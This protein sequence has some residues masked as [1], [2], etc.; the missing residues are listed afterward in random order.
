MPALTLTPGFPSVNPIGSEGLG[1][2]IDVVTLQTTAPDGTV[3]TPADVRMLVEA[4][5][6]G[7]G[8]QPVLSL[9]RQPNQI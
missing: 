4:A 9:Y 2:G 1:K 8:N 3:A 7:N 6:Q 5:L